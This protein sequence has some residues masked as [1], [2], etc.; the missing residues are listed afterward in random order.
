[1]TI[2]AYN[3]GHSSALVLDCTRSDTVAADIFITY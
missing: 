3:I 1:M 2:L